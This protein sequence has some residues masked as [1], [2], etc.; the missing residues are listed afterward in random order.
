MTGRPQ[1]REKQF[2]FY[3]TSQLKIN[4]LLDA[5][6]GRP[7]DAFAV[8][9]EQIRVWRCALHKIM[10]SQCAVDKFPY[11]FTPSNSFDCPGH[12]IFVL[13]C[14]ILVYY[15]CLSVLRFPHDRY[16]LY[17]PHYLLSLNILFRY[18]SIGIVS[19]SNQVNVP[20]IGP[21]LYSS[22]YCSINVG[23]VFHELMS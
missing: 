13:F 6:C 5:V 21:T 12:S 19:Q 22:L 2:F 16:S 23:L 17:R 3:L 15:P 20:P 8:C 11:Y 7:N 18:I 10:F 4:N 1:Q 9:W 14:T